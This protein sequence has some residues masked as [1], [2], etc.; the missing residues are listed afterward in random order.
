MELIENDII[1][2]S[3]LKNAKQLQAIVRSKITNLEDSDGNVITEQTLVLIKRFHEDLCKFNA[4]F[5]IKEELNEEEISRVFISEVRVAVK[6]AK[7]NKGPGP[8]NVEIDIIIEGST[9]LFM[10]LARLFTE[11]IRKQTVPKLWKIIRTYP[12][13]LRKI[14]R[15]I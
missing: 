4:D 13:F 7:R 6:E 2:N 1:N 11:C 8:D 9:I 10:Q 12:S 15:E 14:A 3:S 5:P